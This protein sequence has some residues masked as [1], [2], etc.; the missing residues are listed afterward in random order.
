[1]CKVTYRKE[2][3][4]MATWDVFK[5]LDTLRREIDEAFRGAG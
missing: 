2:V 1:M 3:I 5:E 4:H